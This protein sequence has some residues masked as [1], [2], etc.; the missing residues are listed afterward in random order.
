M[1]RIFDT[2]EELIQHAPHCIVPNILSD[3]VIGELMTEELG[4]NY[5]DREYDMACRTPLAE[6]ER[7][8]GLL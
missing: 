2:T 1:K 4:R 7:R 8:K 5:L 3:E 6:S